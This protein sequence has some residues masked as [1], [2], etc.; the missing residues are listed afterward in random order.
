MKKNGS[1][2][3]HYSKTNAALHDK[4]VSEFMKT[5]KS[6]VYKMDKEERVDVTVEALTKITSAIGYL[7]QTQTSLTKNLYIEKHIKEINT[8]LDRI[9]PEILQCYLNPELLEPV[10]NR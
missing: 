8:K 5:I 10:E 3:E 2:V 4:L 7:Q 6:R 9:P 1:F